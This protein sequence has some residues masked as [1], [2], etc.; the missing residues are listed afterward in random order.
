MPLLCPRCQARLDISPDPPGGRVACPSCQAVFTVGEEPTDT[1]RVAP[2]EETG[3]TSGSGV[4]VQPA[5]PPRPRAADRTGR[6]PWGLLHSSSIR[7]FPVA[8]CTDA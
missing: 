5:V 7:T 2:P 1:P 8:P 4:R 3:I 6:P